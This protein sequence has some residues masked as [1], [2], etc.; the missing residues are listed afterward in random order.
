MAA[1]AQEIDWRIADSMDFGAHDET[2]KIAS[3]LVA[4]RDKDAVVLP[5]DR[6]KLQINSAQAFFK[7]IAVSDPAFDNDFFHKHIIQFFG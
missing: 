7:P 3:S 1:E 2:R 4:T 6:R 5:I